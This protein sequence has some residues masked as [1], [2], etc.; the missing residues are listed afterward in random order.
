[1]ETVLGS[2][3]GVVMALAGFFAYINSHF[4]S[5]ETATEQTKRLDEKLDSIS[6]QIESL[7][8]QMSSGLVRNT[9]DETMNQLAEVFRDVRLSARDRH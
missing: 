3:L 6:R 2:V 5:K 9:V 7:S 8:V 4:V 1:M